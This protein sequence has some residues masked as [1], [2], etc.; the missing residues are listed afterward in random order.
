VTLDMAAEDK[1]SIAARGCTGRA[2][3]RDASQTGLARAMVVEDEPLIRMTLVRPLRMAGFEI[4]EVDSL[5]AARERLERTD[6]DVVVSDLGL[7]DGKATEFLQEVIEKNP[8]VDI[9]LA[10]GGQVPEELDR[11]PIS[12]L[13]KP[14]S[15]DDLKRALGL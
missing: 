8:D 4:F 9:V 13:R 15:G 6:I 5:K 7:P 3:N 1:N 12:I 10:T 14:F 11:M 2:E